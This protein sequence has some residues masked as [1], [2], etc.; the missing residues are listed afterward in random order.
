MDNDVFGHVNNAH[1]YSLFDT[2]VCEFLVGRGILTWRASDHFMVGWGR[3][4]SGG[5]DAER[6]R[7]IRVNQAPVRSSEA[8]LE[9][10]IGRPLGFRDEPGLTDIIQQ[11]EG[12]NLAMREFILAVVRSPEF[13]TK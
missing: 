6:S 13:H 2:A 3:V 10:A 7:S 12:K 4:A 1:Y 8:L 11:A 5:E 9:Y